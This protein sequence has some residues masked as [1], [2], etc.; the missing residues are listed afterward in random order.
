MVVALLGG[1]FAAP[2]FADP[3][4]VL[5]ISQAVDHPADGPGDTFTYTITVDCSSAECINASLTDVL[6]AQFDALTLNSSVAV[7]PPP[8]AGVGYTTSWGGPNNRTLTVNFSEAGGASGIAAGDGYTVQVSMSVPSG[9][10]PDFGS[11]GVAVPNPASVSADDADTKTSA[12]SV[13]VTVPVTV[14]T[15]ITKTWTTTA[16]GSTTSAQYLVG[17]SSVVALTA[18]NTSNALATSLVLQDPADPTS[19]NNPFEDQ[20]FVSFGT[21]SLP[22]GA[23][24]VFVDA[25]VAGAWVAGTVPETA[26][27][28]ALPAGVDPTTV[29]GIRLRFDSSTGNATLVAGGAAGG[30]QLDLAQLSHSR[31]TNAPL[32]HGAAENDIASS[33]VTVPGQTPV[34]ATATAP[35]TILGLT[36]AVGASKSFSPARIPAGESS[37]ALISASN[38]SNGPLLSLTVTEPGTGTFF[39][40]KVSFGGFS[41]TSSWPA[42]A[43]DATVT[44]QVNTGAAPA[45]EHFTSVATMPATPTLAGG[46]YITGFVITYTGSIAAAAVAG[47]AFIVDVTA[48]ENTNETTPVTLTN[49]AQVDGSNDAGAA[50][51]ATAS[52]ALVVLAPQISMIETKT[53]RPSAPII[54]G[55]RSTVQLST[56]TTTDTGYVLPTDITFVDEEGSSSTDYWNAFNAVAI[57]PTQV[58]LGSTLVI[59][60]TTDGSTWI[61]LPAIDATAAATIYSGAL[62]GAANIIGLQFDF[63]NPAG[64]SQNSILNAAISFEARST[65]RTGGA[66][67]A[68]VATSPVTYVNDTTVVGNGTVA[69]GASTERVTGSSSASANGQIKALPGGNNG[70]FLTKAWQPDPKTGVIDVSSQSGETRN[71][72]ISWGTQEDGIASVQVADP[73]DPTQP[74]AST[75]FQAFDLTGIDPINTGGATSTIDPAMAYDEVTAV[76]LYNGTAWIPVPVCTAAA[77]CVGSFPGYTL[78][79]TQ[80]T[81]TVG[82]RITFAPA[83]ST[84][85]V[86]SVTNPP[87]PIG[88]GITS[89]PTSRPIDLVF[90]LRNQLRNPSASNTP[91]SPWVTA[92]D[93]FN[94]TAAGVVQNTATATYV[95]SIST[96]LT[97]TTSDTINIIDT[98]P[99]VSSTKFSSQA[100]TPTS[101]PIPIPVPNPGDVPLAGYPTA[102]YTL[103]ATNASAARAWDLVQTD[104]MPCAQGSLPA[105]ANNNA[106]A[107]K[108]YTVDPYASA[109]YDPTTNPFEQFN[110]TKI[111]PTLSAGSGITLANSTVTLWHY[112]ATTG[113]TS[114]T[115]VA[116]NSTTLTNASLLAD[117][118]GVSIRFTSASTATGGAIA[119]NATATTV[120]SVQLRQT[121]RST[122]QATTPTNVAPTSVINNSFTQIY[123]DVLPDVNVYDS[124]SAT[125][126]LV[127]GTINVTAGKTFTPN[128]L[129]EANRNTDVSVKLSAGS[130]TSTASSDQVVLDDE[131]PGFWNTFALKSLGTIVGPAGANLIEVDAQ[132][133]GSTTWTTETPTAFASAALPAGVAAS[134]VTGLRFTF[135]RNG[136]ALFSNTAPAAVWTASA[137]LIVDVLQNYR[138]SGT[139]VL[140]PSTVSNTVN[141]SSTH[142]I[143]GTATMAATANFTLTTGTFTVDVVKTPSVATTPAGQFVNWTLQ[144]TNTGSGYLNNPTIV[145]QLPVDA[146]L[147][148]G[149]PLIFDP[150][151]VPTYT[152]STGGILSTTTVT[153]TYNPTT[154]QISY[155]W[156]AGSR[157]AP[158]ERYQIVVSLQVAPGLQ[159]SYPNVVNKFTFGSDQTLAS[160]SNTTGTQSETRSGKTCLTSN[161]V[162]VLSASAITTFKGVKGNVDASGNSTSGATNVTNPSASCVADSD[163]FYRTP[164]AANTV[165]GGTDLWKLQL[166][167]GG[168]IPATAATVADVLPH[169]GDTLMRTSTSR[170]STYTPE[171]AG[172]VT[173]IPD[174]LSAGTT[175]TWQVT[176]AANP[177]PNYDSDPTCAAATWVDSTVYPSANYAAVTAIRVVFDFSA[178]AGGTLPPAAGLKVTYKTLNSP[179]LAPR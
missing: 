142:P 117:V 121:T 176:T 134:H 154:R 56:T 119:A 115:T 125:I 174:A 173:L 9:L 19:A 18:Q 144:F 124:K 164:C 11:N 91:T 78:T 52:A 51:P 84:R 152:D 153:Q 24:E 53:I 163:G 105:C 70:T 3:A 123:D 101:I 120:L 165:I 138:T 118:V 104:P 129:L 32:V 156:P 87:P 77:P 33:T 43:T 167:N 79:S 148:A 155:A 62:P 38:S 140:F 50:T 2:A 95:P 168:N 136:G 47:V 149:G 17:G 80:I 88:S 128:T 61:A 145:D 110:L 6:P 86:L 170:G 4:A 14:N 23:N 96:P 31:T 116:G 108:G 13:T 75:V 81:S 74:V 36:S 42:G 162:K 133:D 7:T 37:V 169:A 151:A 147:S 112:N 66:P 45:P 22:A 64:Y 68:T 107:V 102:S 100:P 98:P 73:V 29:D 126:S 1:L 97:D 82:V 137:T 46:Q 159:A 103:T 41:N 94:Q 69:L 166:V 178:L 130:G 106:G 63:S 89:A 5:D 58:P 127:T 28:L 143:F 27:T 59:S 161:F 132:V 48:D 25:W 90:Q 135:T 16:G 99:A 12:A 55:A 10:S 44:W 179:S 109:T 65:L 160:C 92:K 39:T 20:G 49:T 83:D 113:T 34:T 40:P 71:A 35:F 157:L 54:A 26:T 172:G 175:M 114:I 67:T 171:F 57:S 72:R 146:S 141:T 150:T 131:S 158:G 60:Y 15:A 85:S 93:F 21:A 139:P 122:S 177:C 8:E 30:V 111:V 76:E